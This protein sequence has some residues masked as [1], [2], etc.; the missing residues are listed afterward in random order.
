MFKKKYQKAWN[1]IE[2]QL[3]EAIVHEDDEVNGNILMAN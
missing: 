2:E 3:Q 1:I